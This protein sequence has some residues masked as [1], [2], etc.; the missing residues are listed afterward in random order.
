[1]NEC[2]KEFLTEIIISINVI[3]NGKIIISQD[4][5]EIFSYNNNTNKFDLS[6]YERNIEDNMVNELIE[7]IIIYLQT[8]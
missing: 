6:R 7:K 2:I 4:F 5:V 3:K 1:M 8:L